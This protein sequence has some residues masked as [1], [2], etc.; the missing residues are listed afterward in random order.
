LFLAAR[1]FCGSYHLAMAMPLLLEIFK[2]GEV[3]CLRTVCLEMLNS[4]CIF[5]HRKLFC[6]IQAV[7]YCP[8]P[9]ADLSDNQFQNLDWSL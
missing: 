7:V 1:L 9:A 3:K 2:K 5:I 6:F 4:D 8:S